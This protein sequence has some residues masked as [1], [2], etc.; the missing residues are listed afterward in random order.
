LT[1]VFREYTLFLY[2][3]SPCENESRDS[4]K[5]ELELVTV[6]VSVPRERLSELYRQVAALNEDGPPPGAQ[7]GS[8]G[9]VKPWGSGDVEV[10]R[11]LYAMVSANARSI[12]D[13]L[14]KLGD[15]SIGGAQL[16]ANAGID[17]GAY[18]VAGSLSSVGKAAA[19]V[20]RELPYRTTASDQGPGVYGMAETV[21]ELFRAARATKGAWS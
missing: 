16:A 18:G 15:G 21:S 10:A 17:K 3:I 2:G 5:D 7:T 1:L 4:M 11:R 20:G 19:K 12:L 6:S 8:R 14:M 13:Q 9:G